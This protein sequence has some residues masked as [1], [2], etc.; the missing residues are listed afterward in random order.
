MTATIPT[1]VARQDPEADW[2]QSTAEGAAARLQVDP[3]KGLSAAEAQ[4][5]L[6]QYG[7]NVLAE[8][9]TEPAWQRFL[10]QYKEYMQIVLVVA[11][12]VS[13]LIGEYHD[14]LRACCC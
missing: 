5:R 9:T 13:L 3:S 8:A 2:D 11:A 7:P 6:Q 12:V 4:Q 1:T 14:R 10:R